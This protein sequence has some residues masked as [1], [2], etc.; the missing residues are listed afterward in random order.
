MRLIV[1]WSMV[2]VALAAASL[3]YQSLMQL[4][5]LA[6]YGMLSAL[7]P[8]VVDAGAA[9]SCA[10]WL[11]TR[12]R[13]ALA[14]T[15]SLLAVSVVLNGTEHYL[16]STR[17]APSWLL[18]VA[19]AAVPPSVLGLTLHLAV[20]MRRPDQRTWEGPAGPT[21]PHTGL[22]DVSVFTQSH[23]PQT[24][25][26]RPGQEEWG[27]GLAGSTAPGASRSNSGHTQAKVTQTSGARPPGQLDTGATELAEPSCT[28]SR[29]D[30]PQRVRGQAEP[31]APGV[32]R[33][34]SESTSGSN[35]LSE[36]IEQG[37]GRRTIAAEL[38]ITE[39][40]ARKMI[41]ISRNGD[42]RVSSQT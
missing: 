27:S 3:S 11:H 8:L 36:L 15:W 20:D 39:H 7:Y 1:R 42:G 29:L 21:A 14:M 22:R 5:G 28:D 41:S 9:A 30:P 12:G 38:G 24:D 16:E 19:V 13:Q 17:T 4:A 2:L 33:S 23:E 6:G 31:T 35:L 18:V 40:E 10:A 32:Q 26:R 37:A 34:T 25:M